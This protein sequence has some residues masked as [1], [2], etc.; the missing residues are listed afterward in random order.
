V[1]AEED[2]YKDYD[3]VTVTVTNGLITSVA[4]NPASSTTTV[5]YETTG[6]TTVKLKVV[7]VG[8]MTQV[9]IF[10]VSAGVGGKVINVSGYDTG[11][12]IITL[13]GDGQ[14]LDGKTLMVQ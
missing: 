6:V 5:D 12:H 3:Q 10:T 9:D 7:E 8:S 4:P 1:V 2:G 11:A 13:E 14:N